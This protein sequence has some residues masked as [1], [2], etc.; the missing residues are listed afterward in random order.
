MFK[1]SIA[2]TVSLA[3]AGFVSLS[4][5]SVWAQTVTIDSPTANA[6]FMNG[7]PVTVSASNDIASITLKAETFV[8][9]SSSARNS[10]G[11]FVITPAI[12]GTIGARTLNA[13]GFSAANVKLATGSRA[14]TVSNLEWSSPSAGASI[15]SNTNFNLTV[16]SSTATARV[17]YFADTFSLGSYTNRAENFLRPTSL[18]NTGNR[19]LKAVSYNAAGTKITEKS[20]AVT[21]IA[22]PPATAQA[23]LDQA[24]AAAKSYAPGI[25]IGVTAINMDNNVKLS[26][27][28]TVVT[29]HASSAKWLWLAAAL[30]RNSIAAVEPNA[31]PTM[32]DS[33]NTTAGNLIDQAGGL[34]AVNNY[35]E[36]LGIPESGWNSCSWNYDKTR[37]DPNCFRARLNN[38]SWT[39]FF[40]SEAGAIFL[41]KVYRNQM[42]TDAAKSAKLKEWALLSP[43]SGD[44]GWIGTQLPLSVQ[45]G[46]M[47]KE[48][49]IPTAAGGLNTN[50]ELGIVRTIGGKN[51]V[52]AIATEKAA[53]FSTANRVVEYLSC[54]VYKLVEEPTQT[55]VQGCVLG[56]AP[57]ATL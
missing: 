48:G 39:N 4:V 14:V 34:V 19:T 51:Y 6:V 32:R 52:V 7:T 47:H 26:T 45:A 20:I 16:A 3:Q 55:V 12:M 31:I 35:S 29:N 24:V 44:G 5:G 11:K 28:G 27:G 1:Q 41:T 21:V 36:G 43:N 17:E 50:T 54:V 18:L 40:T 10:S 56:T 42:L 23:A 57:A 2:K 13:E 30:S 25:I 22:G 15:I 8:I 46:I 9:G 38:G 49:A 53:S 33:N 37:S